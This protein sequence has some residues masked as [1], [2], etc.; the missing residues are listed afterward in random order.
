MT[1]NV[2]SLYLKYF[3]IE[4]IDPEKGFVPSRACR[5]CVTGLSYW[6]KGQRDRMPFAVPMIWFKPSNH[7]E[8]CYFCSCKTEGYNRKNAHLIKYPDCPRA[9]RPVPHGPDFPAIPVPSELEKVC[10]DDPGK[11][12]NVVMDEASQSPEEPG[13]HVWDIAGGQ[14]NNCTKILMLIH[15]CSFNGMK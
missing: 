9:V 14:P 4:V 8:E 7:F 11:A 15:S 6:S 3:G 10:Q 2:K 13:V 1:D 5:T 12:E